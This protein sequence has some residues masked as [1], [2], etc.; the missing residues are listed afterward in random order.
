V[1][2]PNLIAYE[3]GARPGLEVLV[4][5]ARALR[6]DPWEL[7]TVNPDAPTLADLRL[8]AG[9]TKAELAAHLEMS[10]N[11]WHLVETGKRN[12]RPPVAAAV[13][14]TL[15]VSARR[16]QEAWQRGIAPSPEE[17]P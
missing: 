12:L 15:R 7:T 13:A 5:L 6:V 3:R 11:A 16:V 10:R 2:R 8:R 4:A 17:A 9:L 1:A 14:K